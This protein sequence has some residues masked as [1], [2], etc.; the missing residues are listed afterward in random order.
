MILNSVDFKSFKSPSII[1]SATIATFV[2]SC[3]KI[4]RIITPLT[5]LSL[6]SIPS[7]WK[8][9]AAPTISG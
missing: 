8:Y 4:P 7:A 9:G 1:F 6:V 3:G 2:S 5:I